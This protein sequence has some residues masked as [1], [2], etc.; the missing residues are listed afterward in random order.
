MFAVY[1][2]VYQSRQ[3]SGLDNISCGERYLNSVVFETVVYG[4]GICMEYGI[5]QLLFPTRLY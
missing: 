1:L 2:E 4:A 5:P 3:Y